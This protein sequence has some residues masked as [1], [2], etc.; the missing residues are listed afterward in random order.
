MSSE[1]DSLTFEAFWQEIL[2]SRHGMILD[3]IET[4]VPGFKENLKMFA[5][6]SFDMGYIT[7]QEK[8]QKL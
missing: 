5:G 6:A 2:D 7:A 4:E 8:F 1:L 3:L